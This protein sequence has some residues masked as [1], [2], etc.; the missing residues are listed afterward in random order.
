MRPLWVLFARSAGINAQL[1]KNPSL[2]SSSRT[3][4]SSRNSASKKNRPLL[5]GDLRSQ[6]VTIGAKSGNATT[7]NAIVQDTMPGGS[8]VGTVIASHGG[9]GSH[10]DFKYLQAPLKNAGIRFIGIN[11]PG[12]GYTPSKLFRFRL[13]IDVF[14]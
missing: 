2:N 11:F 5:T 4:C 10:K 13:L 12:F 8:K 3:L 14:V 1:F 7:L 6:R 9:P